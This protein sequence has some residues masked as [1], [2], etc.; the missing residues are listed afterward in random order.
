MIELE[1]GDFKYDVQEASDYLNETLAVVQNYVD[2]GNYSILL[3]HYEADPKTKKVN[4][5]AQGW[6]LLSELEVF[7][8]SGERLPAIKSSTAVKLIDMSKMEEHKINEAKKEHK[9][10]N[11]KSGG[12]GKALF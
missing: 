9:R 12:K 8:S 11:K 6:F 3:Y 4:K 2:E 10:N 5:N 7:K 1:N